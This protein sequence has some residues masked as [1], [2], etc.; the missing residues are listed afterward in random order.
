LRDRDF[1]IAAPLPNVPL[2]L[3][4]H[5]RSRHRTL[6]GIDELRDLVTRQ[7]NRLKALIRQAFEVEDGEQQGDVTTMRMPPF[8]RQSNALPL[9]LAAWQY[10]LVMQW[11]A[12]ATQPAPAVTLAAVQAAVPAAA[13]P[14]FDAQSAARR[15]EVLARMA[16]S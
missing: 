16:G 14:D 12:A 10:D 1:A 13:E 3:S 8:M 7:P 9:T 15:A 2:P 6:S 4:E 11:V 5:A